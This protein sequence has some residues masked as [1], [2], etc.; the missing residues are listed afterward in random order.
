M[1]HTRFVFPILNDEGGAEDDHPGDIGVYSPSSPSLWYCYFLTS[2]N[3]HNL[4]QLQSLTFARHLFSAAS[5]FRKPHDMSTDNTEPD[6]SKVELSDQYDWVDG[7]STNGKPFKIGISKS[8]SQPPGADKAG[9]LQSNTAESGDLQFNAAEAKGKT[10]FDINVKW[11]GRPL[12]QGFMSYNK[13]HA[14]ETR[15]TS[16]T[17]WFLKTAPL[18][19]NEFNFTCT[20]AY[21]FSFYD[22]TGDSYGCNVFWPREATIHFFMYFSNN[23]TIVRITGK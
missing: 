1:S 10:P 6:W 5:H 4:R 15:I 23:P 20:E 19:Y 16:I 12:P 8:N 17:S 11:Q 13:P 14:E 9:D 21:K 7:V 3:N 22:A 2:N 18:N